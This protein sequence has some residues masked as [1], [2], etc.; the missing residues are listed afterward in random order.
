MMAMYECMGAA[1][2]D[3]QGYWT[4]T[5]QQSPFVFVANVAALPLN[6]RA[7]QRFVVLA[8]S[9]LRAASPRTHD[10]ALH[11][12]IA[13]VGAGGAAV[14]ECRNARA[15]AYGYGR[16]ALP[17]RDRP[18]GVQEGADRLLALPELHRWR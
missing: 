6:G 2:R 12:T 18:V 5:G 10:P 15:G 4:N 9:T 1:F 3:A 17:R 11:P 13:G 7:G 16:V 8:D 14:W